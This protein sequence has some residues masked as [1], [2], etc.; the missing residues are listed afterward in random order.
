[1]IEILSLPNF[2][3]NFSIILTFSLKSKGYDLDDVIKLAREIGFRV[4]SI[5]TNGTLPIETLADTVFVSLDG[6]RETNNRLRGDTYDMVMQNI[7]DSTHPSIIINFTIN[8]RNYTEIERFCNEIKEIKQ[9]KGIFFYF[10]TPYY[11]IDKLFLNLEERRA[12]IKRILLLK[13]EGYKILNSTAC[14]KSVYKDNWKRPSKI[15]YVY[16]NNRLYQCCRAFGNDEVCKNCGYL[17][18]TEII[19]I[20]KLKPSAIIS[21]LNYLPR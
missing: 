10:H 3:L 14:L 19:Y 6:L 16:A 13:K 8:K 17:G 2:L 20:L 15:C 9:I 18:Y 4:I 5:Y 7:K 12:I 1:V 21:A 11:G